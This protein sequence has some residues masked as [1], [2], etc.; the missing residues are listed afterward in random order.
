V[1]DRP[2]AVP[3]L[4]RYVDTRELAELMGVSTSTVKR[5]TAAGMPSETWGMRR[6][7]RYLPSNAM[8]W[9]SAR[10]KLRHSPGD[11]TPPGQPQPKE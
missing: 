11:C 10:A 7:R 2:G 8:A 6:T 4:E 3:P 1:S 9:A 5:M